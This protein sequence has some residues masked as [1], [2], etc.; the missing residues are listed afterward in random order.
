MDMHFLLIFIK[1]SF[2]VVKV[3]IDMK[4]LVQEKRIKNNLI[5][6]DFVISV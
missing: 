6:T 4:Q 3:N 1:Y 5:D 2:G